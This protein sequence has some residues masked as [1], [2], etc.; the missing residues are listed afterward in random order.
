ML[1]PLAALFAVRGIGD[2]PDGVTVSTRLAS[3]SWPGPGEALLV[4]ALDTLLGQGRLVAAVA[5]A[6][7][8]RRRGE[9]L[10][11]PVADRV[12]GAYLA[13]GEPAKARRTWLEAAS[14]PSSALRA[15]RL[16]DADL[17]AWDL[18][19]ADAGYRRAL[20][21]DRDLA[22]AWLGLAL[23]ALERGQAGEALEASRAALRLRDVPE[24]HGRALLEGIE[25][26]AAA[27]V[28]VPR[29]GP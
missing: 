4:G 18:G 26:L 9:V 24:P 23:T 21:L 19:G 29:H 7:E 2:A 15:T 16:A 28:G 5:L 17:A 14:P 6:A 10:S 3:P 12:A 27:H 11:W 22:D 8:A 1:R 25:A 13:L 20:A